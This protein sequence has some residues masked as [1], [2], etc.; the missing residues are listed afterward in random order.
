MGILDDDVAR[1]RDATDLVE[2]I[3]EHVALKRVGRRFQGLCPFHNEKTPSFSVNPELGFFYC[4]GCQASGDAITFVRDVEHLDFVG[5]VERLAGRAGITLR[6]DDARVSKDR[7]RRQRLVDAMAAAVDFYHHRLLDG[8]DAKGARGYLR[9]R[10]F[11]GDVARRFQLGWAPGDYDELSRRLQDQKFSRVDLVDA[12]LAFVNRANKLQDQFRAR[13]LFPI[14]DVRGDPVAFGGRSL[15][16]QGPKYKNSPET[17]LYHKS[18]LLYGLNWAKSEIVARAEAIVCEGYTDVMACALADAPNAVATCGTALTDDHVQV[19]KN[20]ARRVTLAYDGDAA[21]QEAAD[22]WYR[23]EQSFDIEVRVAALPSGEDPADIW[24]DDPDRLRTA[25]G[26]A[27]PFL[28]FRLDRM[29]AAAD[30]S[31]VEGRARTAGRAAALVAEHPN[32]LVRDPYVVE[33]SER[34]DIE[35]DR[36]RATVE[37]AS[38]GRSPHVPDETSGGPDPSGAIDRRELDVLRWAVHRPELVVDW[39]SAGL[40]ADMTARATYETLAGAET[41]REAVEVAQ[42]EVRP[43]LERL[44]VEEPR[45]DGQDATTT[46]LLFN[47]VAAAGERLQR[48]LTRAEDDRV[49]EVNRLL[50]ELR[51]AREIGDLAAGEAA[52]KQ[53]LGWI[54]AAE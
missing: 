26:A 18:R 19:L 1:V 32:E 8:S 35:I 13:L 36:M 30:T 39:L 40:F 42:P 15:D 48:A 54:S 31:S 37:Q 5:A 10:G 34:L 53:L 20:F 17:P 4:F 6:Y 27:K 38:R 25:L 33:L 3:G 24:L 43:L 21:G 22:K 23:W 9:S 2:L 49:I 16:D 28:R 14:F 46:N 47:T 45:D 52:A 44:A 7:Q 41:F 12:G 51:H 50:D 29:L 11:D